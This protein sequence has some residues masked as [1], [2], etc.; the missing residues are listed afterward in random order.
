MSRVN[1]EP[2]RAKEWAKAC[3]ILALLVAAFAVSLKV[4]GYRISTVS[5]IDPAGVIQVTAWDIF[6]EKLFRAGEFPLWNPY[7]GLGQPHL[8]SMQPAPFYPLK[9]VGYI[10]GGLTGHDIYLFL[11]LL[12]MGLGPFVLLRSIGVGFGGSIFGGICFG[13]GGY[14]LWFANLVD[15]NNQVLT[16]FLMLAFAMLAERWTPRRF[17][18]AAALVAADVLGGHP[19]ALFISVMFSVFFALFRVGAKNFFIALIRISGAGF[20]GFAAASLLLFPFSE[21]YFRAWHFHFNGMGFLHIWPRALVTVFSPI[22]SHLSPGAQ[23]ELPRAIEAMTLFDI[24][25]LPYSV[26]TMKAPL[27]YLGFIAAFLAAYGIYRF[28]RLP[29]ECMFFLIFFLVAGGLSMGLF[30]FRLLSF[31]PPFSLMNNAKFYFCELTFSLCMI[32]GIV[33]GNVIGRLGRKSVLLIGALIIELALCSL[34][35]K[36]YVPVNW[37]KSIKAPWAKG[38]DLSLEGYRFQAGGYFLFPP[39]FGVVRGFSDI[40]S[41]DALFP[42]DYFRWIYEAGEI[43]EREASYDFYPRYFTRLNER[44][45]SSDAAALMGLKYVVEEVPA[46]SLEGFNL[47]NEDGYFLYEKTDVCP[48][49]FVSIGAVLECRDG[50][51]YKRA[52]S[53]R[54]EAHVESSS[55]TV[56]FSELRYPGWR[57]TLD[58]REVKQVKLKAPLQAYDTGGESGKL[59]IEYRPASFRIGLWATVSTLLFIIC[60]I[61]RREAEAA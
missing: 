8:G 40:R 1:L 48:R 41:S 49:L 59:V 61:V 32:A 56:V 36:P 37:E 50:I 19:E 20:I 10:V 44:A 28:K 22:F 39:N 60:L 55:G 2:P 57:A 53:Q 35:V 43:P 30:P 15:A 25:R 38:L 29:R 52:N 45:L 33:A 16:P 31:L 13:F 51:K 7:A 46:K 24:Y 26:M 14:S 11:R 42:I 4:R 58:G 47:I 18:L 27:P 12:L 54:V 23:W 6:N 21:Y 3:L 5:L 9:L 17:A 34:T